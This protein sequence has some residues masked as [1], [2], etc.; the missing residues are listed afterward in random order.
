MYVQPFKHPFFKVKSRE[1]VRARWTDPDTNRDSSSYDV[2]I[3]GIEEGAGKHFLNGPFYR[4]ELPI[5]KDDLDL[6]GLKL[7]KIDHDFSSGGDNFKGISF[8]H[9]EWWHCNFRNCVFFGCSLDFLEA[10]NC[11]FE[12]CAFVFTHF[13][14]AKFEKC[15]FVDC[16]FGEPCSWENGNFLNTTFEGCFLGRTSPFN[17]CRFDD[18][19]T[20]SNMLP[21]SPH[22]GEKVST[23]NEALSG[24]YSSFQSAYESSG[25][26]ELANSY[27]WKARKAYTRHNLKGFR[28]FVALVNEVLTG[29]GRRPLRPL[30]MIGLAFASGVFA[31]SFPLKFEDSLLL[32]AGALFTFGAST[33]L[34]EKLGVGWRLLYIFLS[35][36]GVTGTAMFITSLATLW[37]HS[38]V[39][40]PTVK[41]PYN[42]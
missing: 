8:N 24:Y 34:L 7:W 30:L 6:R 2:V 13:V 36:V 29:Y 3:A 10:Y 17:E 33:G 9:G 5:L 14:G 27:Y 37:F 25:A 39:P 20:V 35:F 15:S 26:E 1:E 4:G 22:Y 31:F 11:T 32:T 12:K 23:P 16:D 28:R 41:T 18:R 42:S 38:K 21:H 40:N 19:T